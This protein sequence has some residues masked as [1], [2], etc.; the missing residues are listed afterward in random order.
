MKRQRPTDPASSKANNSP[1]SHPPIEGKY[2]VLTA[3]IKNLGP[4]R[5]L[6]A[7]CEEGL[8]FRIGDRILGESEIGPIP[9][10]LVES[11]RIQH[12]ESAV[13]PPQ[14]RFIRP[15]GPGDVSKSVTLRARESSLSIFVRERSQSRNLGMSVIEVTGNLAAT[16][17][18]IYYTAEGRVDF[19]E[20]VKDIHSNFRGRHELRQI[21]PREHSA[22]LDGIGPCGKALCCST[23]LREFQSVTT[24]QARDFDPEMNPMK[25]TGMCGRLKCCLSYEKTAER[26]EEWVPVDNDPRDTPSQPTLFPLATLS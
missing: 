11:P 26:R 3:Q 9:M 4:N 25:T 10:N 8:T 21:S 22:L 12:P 15:M 24:R 7:P 19:R 5:T 2:W 13:T 20:L 6:W 23:F 18:I 17:F 14:Y 1:D 16:E